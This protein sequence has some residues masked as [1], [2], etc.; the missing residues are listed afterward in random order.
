[1]VL[2]PSR[3]RELAPA[4]FS[5]E[6]LLYPKLAGSSK[7]LLAATMIPS[8]IISPV[9]V[10]AISVYET[11]IVL[12]HWETPWRYWPHWTSGSH[13]RKPPV[14]TSVKFSTWGTISLH[15]TSSWWATSPPI[16]FHW[17]IE[18]NII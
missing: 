12:I 16:S 18:V 4:L 15:R 11:S 2:S 8:V 5:A 10:V 6:A 9:I 7:V 13:R 1:M 3:V 17:W 14:P